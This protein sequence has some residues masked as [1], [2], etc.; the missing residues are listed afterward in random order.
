M[1]DEP[2]SDIEIYINNLEDLINIK[3]KSIMQLKNKITKFKK[4]IK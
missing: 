4:C 2:G 3:F 1:V